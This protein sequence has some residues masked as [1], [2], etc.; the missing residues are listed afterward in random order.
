MNPSSSLSRL[1]NYAIAAL[2]GLNIVLWLI[3]LPANDGRPDFIRQ[4]IAEMLSST[5]MILM[6]C[7]IVLSLRLPVLE[8]FFGGLDRMY[9][10][11]KTAALTGLGLV[12]LHFVLIPIT[13]KSPLARDLGRIALAGF[14]ILIAL[15]L[16]PRVPVIN[17]YVQLAYHQWKYTHRLVGAF[18]ILGMIHAFNA[19][20]LLYTAEPAASFW[21][22]CVYA[23]AAAYVY[24]QLLAPLLAK[25]AGYV[26]A[27]VRR[28]NPSTVEVALKPDG[29]PVRQRA[30]QFAFVRFP[31]EPG[32][33]E[34]HPF[35]VSSAPG[36]AHLRFTIKASGDWTKALH[37]GLREGAQ[38]RVHGAHGGFDF[39]VGGP[40]QIWVAG[41]IGVTPFLSWIR[42]LT[43]AP[44]QQIAFFYSVRAEPDAVFW[45]EFQAAAGRFPSLTSVRNV[46]STDG[47]LTLD[48]IKAGCAFDVAGADVYLCGPPPMVLAF[49][50][51]FRAAGVPAGKIHYE[52]F[53]FR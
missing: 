42:S 43:D 51:Q 21:R 53:N 4:I 31:G 14:L 5:G 34:S 33:G 20:T 18:F 9:K 8:P 50:A 16:A 47:S 2:A 26:V 32:L 36:E 23:S 38:A 11:H 48:K 17:G 13:G 35:T 3:G 49:A 46:S 19:P 22:V 30:G 45:D 12:I 25:G 10:S 44:A 29:A 7:A 40:R 28:L 39:R 24:K 37:A 27:S 52:E 1:G 6:G 41:G 15:T